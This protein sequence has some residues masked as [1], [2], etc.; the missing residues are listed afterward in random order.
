MQLKAGV[1][2]AMNALTALKAT[3]E[4]REQ[5][6]QIIADPATKQQVLEALKGA[7]DPAAVQ[8]IRDTIQA[9]GPEFQKLLQDPEIAAEIQ[10][11]ASSP[12]AKDIIQ[13]LAPKEWQD[14]YATYQQFR[15]V[16]LPIVDVANK[17][18]G[19]L[20]PVIG[21]L[22]GDAAKMNPMIKLLFLL[23][24]GSMFGSL[25]SGSG[26]LGGF[27]ALLLMGGLVGGGTADKFTNALGWKP[28]APAAAPA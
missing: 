11:S 10:R 1:A 2:T 26:M 5:L 20:D 6:R 15:S 17:V 14:A 13:Q 7:G 18:G 23:G 25:L 9:I 8:E 24:G 28:P 19:I 3:P 21:M 16:G 22:G 4:G 27:G 12:G